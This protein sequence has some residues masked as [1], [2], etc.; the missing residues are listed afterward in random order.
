MRRQFLGA[1]LFAG[2]LAFTA[3]QNETIIY[4]DENGNPIENV[5]GTDEILISVTNTSASSRA[6]RP[7]GSSAAA[8]NVNKVSIRVYKSNVDVTE[9]VLSNGTY[10]MNWTAGP[11]GEGAP[12]AVDREASQVLKLNNL[13]ANA[14]YRI[15][16]YGY[17][18]ETGYTIAENESGDFTA[19]AGTLADYTLPELFAGELTIT[20]DESKKI[21]S[22]GK[23]EVLLER[24][25]AGMI[26][27]FENV[28]V[29]LLNTEDEPTKVKYVR[30]YANAE[31]TGFKFSSVAN[32]LNGTGTPASTDETKGENTNKYLLME[33]NMSLIASDYESQTASLDNLGKVY[34]MKSDVANRLATGYTAPTSPSLSLKAGSM[35]GGRYILPYSAHVALQTITI[36]LQDE[37]NKALKTL[38]VYTTNKAI[39]GQTDATTS[40]Y[41]IRRN[42][43][44][45]IGKKYET[46]STEGP[47][48]GDTDDDDKPIDLSTSNE[49]IVTINDAWDVLHD[50]TVTED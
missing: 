46:G 32:D 26:G 47:D 3:C 23:K 5:L 28:P 34:T 17:N 1:L 8:N 48:G 10:E 24:Q 15:V 39:S 40:Q 16:A 27:Y 25:V 38:N 42:N 13:D 30:V 31:T 6:A 44:Y 2:T 36:E 41:D 9:T 45:S 4:V 50:M 29:C 21:N 43:F 14:T 20:T 12:T 11:T 22:T 37:N 18:D 19:S 33:F 49:I 35:F 7:V